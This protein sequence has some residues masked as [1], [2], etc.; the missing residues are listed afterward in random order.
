MPDL[1][2]VDRDLGGVV[3]RHF[4]NLNNSGLNALDKRRMSEDFFDQQIKL[5]EIRDEMA[6]R[7]QRID[8]GELR[9]EE[10]QLQLESLRLRVQREK[11]AAQSGSML[12]ADISAILDGN[13][14]PE[15]K[16]ERLN[17]Y[18]MENS[19]LFSNSESARFKFRSALEIAD[20]LS[21]TDKSLAFRQAQ[22]LYAE[23]ERMEEE[24][25]EMEEKAHEN[26]LKRWDRV[27]KDFEKDY[28]AIAGVDIQQPDAL[29]GDQTPKLKNPADREVLLGFIARYSPE[30]LEAAQS[31][32]AVGLTTLATRVGLAVRSGI[33]QE[34]P[35]AAPARPDGTRGG[36]PPK[37]LSKTKLF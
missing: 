6:L 9:K 27:N 10:A 15:E 16:K 33:R 13:Y 18:A 24:R 25:R 32:D 31:M 2:S 22:L 5:R 23:K 11:D 14:S 30:Q 17:R 35:G 7:R 37:G 29:S 3:P 34:W 19:D 26:E 21:S 36:T 1:F 4:A 20:P 28:E 12:D 8:L